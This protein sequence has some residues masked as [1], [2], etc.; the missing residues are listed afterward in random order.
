MTKVVFGK[1][2]WSSG[3]MGVL[4]NAEAWGIGGG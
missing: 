2:Y 3:M 1:C 4:E